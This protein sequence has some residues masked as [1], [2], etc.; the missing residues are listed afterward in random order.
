MADRGTI[1]REGDL[2]FAFDATWSVARHSDTEPVR[3]ALRDQV[4]ES[5]GVDLVG[6]GDSARALF[7]IE[8]KDYRTSE[9]RG[10][11]RRKLADDGRSLAEVVAAKVRD[12]VAGLIGAARSDRDPDWTITRRALDE[13]VWVVLWIEHAGVERTTSVRARR[14]RID[15]G[16]LEQSIGRRCRWL[17]ARALVCSRDGL[18]LPGL[19][20]KSIP[21][22]ART[23]GRRTSPA[24][25]T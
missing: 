2:D 9:G 24:D 15:A 5:R 3:L 12:T 6:V 7:L 19:T 13:R 22:A 25:A 20:V 11:T 8:V 4:P 17:N 21:G 18:C 14:R 10:S 16:V 1:L 23:P